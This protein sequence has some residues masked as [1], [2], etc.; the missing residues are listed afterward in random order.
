MIS[1]EVFLE[2]WAGF[3]ENP[4]ILLTLSENKTEDILIS[5]ASNPATTDEIL[6]IIA[7]EE[8]VDLDFAISTRE[9]LSPEIIELLMNSNF[10]SVRREIARRP[11]LD[12]SSYNKLATDAAALVREAIRQNPACSQE[13]K[14]LAALGSL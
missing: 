12:D 8:D 7:S 9:K 6:K 14:A 1:D 4:E 3:E 10:E 5:L 2:N 11:D 13:I